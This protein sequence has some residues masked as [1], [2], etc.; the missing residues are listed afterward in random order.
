MTTSDVTARLA[1]ALRQLDWPTQMQLNVEF[2]MLARLPTAHAVA[3]WADGWLWR[4]DRPLG[5]DDRSDLDPPGLDTLRVGDLVVLR[6]RFGHHRWACADDAALAQWCRELVESFVDEL[7]HRAWVRA[8]EAARFAIIAAE[9]NR[10]AREG[11]PPPDLR[12]LPTWKE[13]S[14]RPGDE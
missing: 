12:G 14:R 11:K 1:T 3:A 4:L 2:A 7:D 9:E 8:N 5:L 13:I 10:R 6:D